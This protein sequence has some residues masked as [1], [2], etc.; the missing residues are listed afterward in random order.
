[1]KK[2][3]LPV[4]ALILSLF[5][6]L[7]SA[8]AATAAAPADGNYTVQFTVLKDG[9]DTAS[10]MDTYTVKPA[11]IKVTNGQAYAYVTLKN[12]SWI[13][14]F[15][16]E[17]NGQY[18]NAEVIST[19]PTANTRVVGFPVADLSAKLNAYTEVSV[20]AIGYSGQYE[21]QFKFDTAT[22]AAVAQ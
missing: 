2:M 13:T 7:G 9:T 22:L 12:S 21:V 5:T 19:N 18:V 15:Q 20:P 1:M 11:Q 17:Q 16:V 6:V 3:M 8:S 10:M 14:K 4:M